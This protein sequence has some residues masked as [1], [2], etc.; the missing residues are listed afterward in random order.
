MMRDEV[1]VE[2]VLYYASPVAFQPI[3]K[4]FGARRVVKTPSQPLGGE[5]EKVMSA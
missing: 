4:A 5:Q 3:T 1:I 2:K